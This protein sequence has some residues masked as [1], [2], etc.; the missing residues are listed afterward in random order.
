MHHPLPAVPVRN[1]PPEW[2]RECRQQWGDREQD[3]T[4]KGGLPDIGHTQELGIEGK[5]GNDEIEAEE[6]DE[7]NGR[8]P[9]GISPPRTSVIDRVRVRNRRTCALPSEPGLQWAKHGTDRGSHP[10]AFYDRRLV[11]DEPRNRGD[12]TNH[13]VSGADQDLDGPSGC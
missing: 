5:Q 4:E 1:D 12:A 9:T 6:R 7:D 13:A 2:R 10:G 3:T 8:H 11:P